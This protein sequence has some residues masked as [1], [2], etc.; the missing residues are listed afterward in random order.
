MRMMRDL[1]LASVPY[2]DPT[3]ELM[4]V[5]KNPHLSRWTTYSANTSFSL[6]KR[7]SD[8]LF[9]RH[10]MPVVCLTDKGEMQLLSKPWGDHQRRVLQ[11][12]AHLHSRVW[13]RERIW[14]FSADQRCHI[15]LEVAAQVAVSDVA[16]RRYL[17]H[18]VPSEHFGWRL[19]CKDPAGDRLNQQLRQKLQ[20]RHDRLLRARARCYVP[21][22]SPQL[23]WHDG[24][25]LLDRDAA[26]AVAASC[27][28]DV[29]HHFVSAPPASTH[30]S[31]RPEE[32][33]T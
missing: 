11:R 12:V 24:E 27:V 30:T 28:I 2:G 15:P 9:F 14:I 32:A 23:R 19:Q 7:P 29:T 5:D 31:T 6:G 4:H 17:H 18:L 25:Q 21:V 13:G 16:L 8:L 10:G 33:T 1:D 20:R 26:I 3:Y 22:S